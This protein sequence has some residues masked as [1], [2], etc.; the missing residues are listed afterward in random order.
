M[1]LGDDTPVAEKGVSL[2]GGQRQRI[3]LARA[4]YRIADVYLLDNPVSALDDQ[5]QHHIW[6]HLIEGLL[7]SATVIVAASRPVTSCGAVLKLSSN[8]VCK[9]D[10]VIT[11]YNGFVG[12][13]ASKEPPPRYLKRVA[14]VETS[15]FASSELVFNTRE[16]SFALMS[17][18][19]PRGGSMNVMMKEVAVADVSRQVRAYTLYSDEIERQ[20]IPAIRAR[21]IQS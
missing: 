14:P 18:V 10:A 9:N 16:K 19:R 15:S 11:Q 1:R 13:V 6:T 7:Q 17:Q 4:A 21:C 8:G 20:I 5:T 3:G 2:S 12:A